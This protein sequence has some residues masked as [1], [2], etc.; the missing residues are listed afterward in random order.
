[1]QRMLLNIAVTCALA[2]AAFSQERP[3]VFISDSRSWEV[4]GGFGASR[5]DAGGAFNGGARPQTVEVMKTFR[6]RC[7]E[8]TVTSDRTRAD[9]VVLL[10]HEGGKGLGRDNKIAVFERQGDLIH[11]SSTRMLGN[12]VKDACKV[13]LEARR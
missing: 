11:T 5:G 9:F 1:M 3:R 10:D 6:E 8:T 2:G 13:I 12:A 4:G 7:P